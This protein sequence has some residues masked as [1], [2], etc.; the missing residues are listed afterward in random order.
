MAKW[1]R[2]KFAVVAEKM[3]SES[4]DRLQIAP[5]NTWDE[6][7]RLGSE[8]RKSL[9]W[10]R[11]EEMADMG[12]FKCFSNSGDFAVHQAF[13]ARNAIFSAPWQTTLCRD[14]ACPNE[15]RKASFLSP[16]KAE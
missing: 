14:P 1:F 15:A 13:S 9:G 12:G 11:E 10:R 3:T 6:Q 8:M 2:E 4:R 5:V 16:A 7:K